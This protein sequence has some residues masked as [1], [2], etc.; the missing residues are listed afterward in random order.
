[1]APVLDTIAAWD[2]FDVLSLRA[3]AGR[4]AANGAPMTMS[5]PVDAAAQAQGNQANG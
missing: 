1:V 4:G 5:T 3:R 2:A